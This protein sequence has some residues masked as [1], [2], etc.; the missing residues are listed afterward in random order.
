MNGINIKVKA[1]YGAYSV[2][3]GNVVIRMEVHRSDVS[4]LLVPVT[5]IVV[6][7]HIDDVQVFG[8]HRHLVS[9]EGSHALLNFC[10]ICSVKSLI[11]WGK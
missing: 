4:S 1:C 9:C 10:T 5:V 3:V 11:S 6:R 8:E 7:H 2:E